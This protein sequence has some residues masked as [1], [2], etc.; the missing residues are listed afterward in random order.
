MPPSPRSAAATLRLVRSTLGVRFLE[1]GLRARHELDGQFQIGRLSRIP[2]LHVCPRVH[3]L[4]RA[5]DRSNSAGARML[6]LLSRS[7]QI[8]LSKSHEAT[9]ATVVASRSRNTVFMDICRKYSF[10]KSI[11]SNSSGTPSHSQVTNATSVEGGS[12]RDVPANGAKNSVRPKKGIDRLACAYLLRNARQAG[13]FSPFS[14]SIQI[15]RP[16]N[17]SS[18]HRS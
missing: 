13:Q 4:S 14:P 7:R 6:R 15:R 10:A 3:P 16:A 18:S 8:A 5:T 17:P 2:R 9:R 11:R 1:M 12:P